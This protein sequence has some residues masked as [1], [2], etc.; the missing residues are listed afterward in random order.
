MIIPEEFEKTFTEKRNTKIFLR[1]EMRNLACPGIPNLYKFI[2]TFLKGSTNQKWDDIYSKFCTLVPKGYREIIFKYVFWED[3][4]GKLKS[5]RGTFYKNMPIYKRDEYYVDKNG[6]LKKI[7]WKRKEER[8]KVYKKIQKKKK[9]LPWDFKYDYTFEFTMY[10]EKFE[11]NYY[12]CSV[13][14]NEHQTF[15]TIKQFIDW[16]EKN[17]K[18]YIIR[19][20][21]KFGYLR[22]IK[23]IY[24]KAEYER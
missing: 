11:E 20:Y 14:I 8:K 12:T 16:A 22:K 7:V 17:K 23:Q 24:E 5:Y 4:S 15:F 6:I 9:A 21:Q 13:W 2:K 1:K 3:D 19:I 18:T 10:S